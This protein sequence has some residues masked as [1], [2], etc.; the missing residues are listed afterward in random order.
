MN[1]NERHIVRLK[2]LNEL[3]RI[4]KMLAGF[5]KRGEKDE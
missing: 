4:R 1:E 3:T 2:I 5:T